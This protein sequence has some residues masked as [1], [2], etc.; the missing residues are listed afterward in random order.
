MRT[1]L[2]LI[3]HGS[4]AAA[5]NDDLR[6]LADRIRGRGEH[7]AVVASFLELADPD[8]PSAARASVA[9]GA[10][11]VV[12]CPYFLSAGTH[13]R[14]DLT[15]FRDDLA[16]EFPHVAFLLAEPLGQHPSLEALVLQRAD[17]CLS[18]AAPAP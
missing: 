12:L 9:D 2:V 10:E 4:R 16:R 3:A 17:E 5:A 15:A 6:R 14:R 7:H 11:R 8:I 1:A 18:E 13:V